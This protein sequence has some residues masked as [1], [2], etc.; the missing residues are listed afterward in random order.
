MM[1]KHVIE[2]DRCGERTD[3]ADA[4]G[5]IAI[6]GTGAVNQPLFKVMGKKNEQFFH[7][8]HD[9]HFCSDTCLLE[10]LHSGGKRKP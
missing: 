8:E 6:E 3:R 10:W 1:H 4:E 7:I 5:W 9:V 2:C